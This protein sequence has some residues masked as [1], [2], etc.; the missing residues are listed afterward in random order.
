MKLLNALSI[1]TLFFISTFCSSGSESTN[2]LINDIWALKSIEGEDYKIDSTLEQQ[3]IIEIHLN[4]ERLNGNTGCNQMDG[5]VYVKGNEIVFTDII[6]TKM[7]CGGNLEQ[8]FLSAL[9]KVN[10]YKIEKMRLFLYEDKIEK[11]VLIK[12]D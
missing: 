7:F 9:S 11:L 3:P 5:K 10:N 4:D 6:T 1:T 8:K 2:V 12:V